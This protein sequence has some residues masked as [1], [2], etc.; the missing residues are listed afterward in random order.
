MERFDGIT[1][2][3]P[4]SREKLDRP[5]PARDLYI[6]SMFRQTLKCAE[7]AAARDERE[8]RGPTRILVMS[9]E[10]GFVHLDQVLEPYDTTIPKLGTEAAFQL[11]AKLAVQAYHLGLGYE[12]G[13]LSGEVSA[14]VPLKYFV[15][16]D[17]ALRELDVYPIPM[18]E[19][20][21]GI[22]DQ[23]RVNANAGGP[24]D[25]PAA[26]AALRMWIGG[27]V[28]A[29]WTGEPV[30][31]SYGRLVRVSGLPV[32]TAPWVLDSR[33]FNE[34]ADHG[35]WT[36]PAE[37]YAA[38]VRG[39]AERIG[40][41][42]WVAPQDWPACRAILDVTGLTEDKH[43]RLT[44]ESVVELRRMLAGTG[45]HVVVVLTGET[46]DG[47]LRHLDIYR[48]YGI[49]VLAETD[50]VG[51]GALVG[52]APTEAA[53]IIARL[54]QAGVRRMHGFGVKGKALEMVHPLLESADTSN[55]SLYAR[56]NK[57]RLPDCTHPGDCRNCYRYAVRWRDELLASLPTTSEEAAVS[58]ALTR[59]KGLPTTEDLFSGLAEFG[60]LFT[61][62][63][64]AKKT[65]PR[66]TRP[67]G[68]AAQPD[69]FTDL[70]AFGTLMG[71]DS[72]DVLPRTIAL[73]D[74]EWG[75]YGEITKG[76]YGPDGSKHKAIRGYITKL[77]RIRTCGEGGTNR[78]KFRGK[79]MLSF[80]I[81]MPFG[82]R[83][84]GVYGFDIGMMALT[85]TSFTVMQPP[86]DRPLDRQMSLSRRLAAADLRAGDVFYV[87]DEPG[88]TWK[89]DVKTDVR[90]RYHV[91]A[92][93]TLV[94]GEACD[95]TVLV[96]GQGPVITRRCRAY[97]YVDLVD[98]R[99]VTWVQGH[100]V[101]A[102]QLP[103]RP[104]DTAPWYGWECSCGEK[105]A[106]HNRWSHRELAQQQSDHHAADEAVEPAGPAAPEPQAQP[107]EVGDGLDDVRAVLARATI[108]GATLR[109]PDETLDRQ[110]WEAT[111]AVLKGM[112]AKGGA[113]KGQPY[114]FTTD[115]SADLFA[116]IVGGAAPKHERTTAGWVRTPDKVAVDVVARFADVDRL[117]GQLEPGRTLRVLEPSAG[118]GALV[119]AVLAAVPA[120]S[121]DV[122]AVEQ[123]A[124]RAE[125]LK[126]TVAGGGVP[127]SVH[128]RTF[129]DFAA[130]FEPTMLLRFNLVVMNPP[131]S[132]PGNAGLWAKHVKLA[133]ELLA[134]GGRLVAILPGDPSRAD[135][136]IDAVLKLVGRD[137][138]CVPLPARSFRQRGNGGTDVDTWV[139]A[140]TKP[141]DGVEQARGLYEASLYYSHTHR[142]PV[143]VDQVDVSVKAAV[144]MPAQRFRS[145]GG[146]DK[147][148]YYV[149]KCIGCSAPC[150]SDGDNHPC[151]MLG[152]N[153]VAPLIA[154]E[155]GCVGPDVCLCWT[156]YDSATA[157]AV[158]LERARTVWTP[159]EQ[160]QP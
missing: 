2:V 31:V 9:A 22:G 24:V 80:N 138:Q 18:Y 132:T 97:E 111:H 89:G 128:V 56:N 126:Q 116:F 121:V 149:G 28:H 124:D 13:Q 120:P 34:L 72:T 46:E 38:D 78:P 43:Q 106:E 3:V 53:R 42:R 27:D 23:R 26:A 1:Y 90:P 127:V 122:L 66:R 36:I 157:T 8:G 21:R 60:D 147:V 131:Y 12:E 130:W 155:R 103:A 51:V 101:A 113:R 45:V 117:V 102:V 15:V 63:E 152:M 48:E 134:P 19:A 153:A 146:G 32:A 74:V 58:T 148:A 54:H 159:A 94:D 136:R 62:T 95:I 140:A 75:M 68:P 133:W 105:S 135:L 65:S 57:I 92:Q 156:C 29:L 70:A 17:E 99:D 112:G 44:A 141:A 37:Q 144:E 71:A 125:A 154:E 50:V 151:G 41:L 85:D 91:Q 158:G 83:A 143:L 123:N 79:P 40:R 47:Y 160:D 49:D 10:H 67:A 98:P 61:T 39:Y 110:L 107:A 14:W 6:G 20:C 100:A 7:R 84:A 104:G 4:C 93:P 142:E 59:Q 139:L 11:V 73:A 129:E 109:L 87:W 137:R 30:M 108:D 96:A 114:R 55:W 64:P 81:Y 5:A 35:Q 119:K 145:F 76:I 86:P 82:D 118:D 33:G 77:P 25:E 150:W 88:L 16:L 115:R 69:L 52:R